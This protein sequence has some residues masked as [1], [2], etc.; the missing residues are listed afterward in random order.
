MNQPGPD[1]PALERAI[2]DEFAKVI[3]EVRE[4]SDYLEFSLLLQIEP[5]LANLDFAN[6]TSHPALHSAQE[7]LRRNLDLL[8]QDRRKRRRT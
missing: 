4:V 5:K 2:R 6:P 8:A 1:F 7:R 3:K